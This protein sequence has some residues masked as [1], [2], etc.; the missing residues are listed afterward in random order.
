MT[1]LIQPTQAQAIVFV[2]GILGFACHKLLCLRLCYFRGLKERFAAQ[3][4][5]LH[6]PTL[7]P[8]GSVEQRAMVLA[9]F[10]EKIPAERI[11]LIAHSMGG[12]DGR[13]LIHHL[14]KKHRVCRLVTI[15]TP[16][17]GTP[18]AH[19]FLQGSGPVPWLGRHLAR[20]GADDLTPEVCARFNE[21]TPD[22]SDVLYQSYAGCRPVAEMA[23]WFKPWARM[24]MEESGDNDSQV[25]VSSARWGEFL[26]TVRADHL[27]LVG[28]SLAMPDRAVVRPFGHLD[29]YEQMVHDVLIN[30]AG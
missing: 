24:I 21:V 23:P 6:F 22:R 3:G 15:G 7:P 9:R 13:Y 2:H 19:W 1:M 14:D 27:E 12:L 25:P 28:W 8:A 26:G 11:C 20:P 10:L 30:K 29:F 18:L 16:H 17:R 4:V 5:S